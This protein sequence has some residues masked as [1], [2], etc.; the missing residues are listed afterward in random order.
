[1]IDYLDKILL[2]YMDGVPGCLIM[3]E[4]LAHWTDDVTNYKIMVKKV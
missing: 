1:M 3:D 2:P 4:Y